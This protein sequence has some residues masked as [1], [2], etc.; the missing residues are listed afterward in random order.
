MDVYSKLHDAVLD[1]ITID[2]EHA[3]VR[4]ELQVLTTRFALC[5][6]QRARGPLTRNGAVDTYLKTTQSDAIPPRRNTCRL[7]ANRLLV[8]R[9][10]SLT[11]LGHIRERSA[12]RPPPQ[13]SQP[14]STPW[15]PASRSTTRAAVSP[16]P[17]SQAAQSALTSASAGGSKARRCSLRRRIRSVTWVVT[18]QE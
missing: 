4:L 6:D 9:E 16:P 7:A 10:S 13:L 12:S 8:A 17:G 15:R 14:P 3:E 2:W 5:L 11:E 1:G 18:P